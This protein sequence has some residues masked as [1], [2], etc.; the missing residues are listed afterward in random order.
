MVELNIEIGQEFKNVEC[1]GVHPHIL[2]YH[3]KLY[4]FSIVHTCQKCGSTGIYSIAIPKS[5]RDKKIAKIR[6]IEAQKKS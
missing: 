4:Q 2:E 6:K 5:V 3:E 1:C